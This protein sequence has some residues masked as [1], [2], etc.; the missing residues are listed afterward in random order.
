MQPAPAQ[1]V[2]GELAHLR[3][4]QGS[5]CTAGCQVG[6]GR[7]LEGTLNNLFL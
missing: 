5:A 7:G 2:T 4:L 6:K 1:F 3:R